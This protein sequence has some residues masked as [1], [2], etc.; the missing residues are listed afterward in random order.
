MEELE[1]E[2]VENIEV[3]EPLYDQVLEKAGELEDEHNITEKALYTATGILMAEGYR[4][5]RE[6]LG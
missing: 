4:A 3:D 6:Y 5:A 2:A 1:V